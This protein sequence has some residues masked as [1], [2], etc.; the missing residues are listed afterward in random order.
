MQSEPVLVSLV[1]W[2]IFI[3]II[4]ALV[5][6]KWWSTEQD[7]KRGKAA[8]PRPAVTQP[9]P[10]SLEELGAE[11]TQLVLAACEVKRFQP[12]QIALLN[13]AKISAD[14]YYLEIVSL[15]I[16]A[17]MTVSVYLID[18]EE[19]AR[20][21]CARVVP[22]ARRAAADQTVLSA[23]LDHIMLRRGE[24]YGGVFEAETKRDRATT[25]SPMANILFGHLLP[26]EPRKDR[27]DNGARPYYG[28]N[29]ALVK[30]P[31]FLE[32]EKEIAAGKELS[33]VSIEY[34]YLAAQQ[35]IAFLQDRG[36]IPRRVLA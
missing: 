1:G 7:L 18:D 21:L 22:V 8:P 23:A 2:P 29:G 5:A 33:E 34:F 19:K 32:M 3:G 14:I 20:A 27:L 28:V 11:M 25:Q 13:R 31:D 6:W 30:P 12:S 9:G 4:V 36:V 35:T 24:E 16:S 10:A 15:M 26:D 17:V